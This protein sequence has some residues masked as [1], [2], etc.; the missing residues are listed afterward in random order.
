[1]K[2]QAE[3]LLKS[4]NWHGIAEV[5]FRV[6]L[7][8]GIPKLMEINPRFWGSLEV[9]VRSG[10]D[11][12]YLLYRIAMDGD[13][14]TVSSYKV[15]VKGR[16]MAQD[17]LYIVSLFTDASTNPA[18]RIPKRFRMLLGWLRIY[19]P[20]V[21]YDL[22]NSDD[23]LPFLFTLG[24]SPLDVASFLRQERHAWSPPGVRF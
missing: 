23:P 12:P 18:I 11:F 21:F 24:L 17:I 14:N 8:D 5:E 22:L 6:D 1:M 7:R 4:L 19:E 2:R 13:V 15:G 20:E 10:V 9:A 16:Y 3:T